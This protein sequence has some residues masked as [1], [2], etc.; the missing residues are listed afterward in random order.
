M[1]LI[2]LR[3]DD[4]DGEILDE[5]SRTV[6]RVAEDVSPAVVRVQVHERR[7]DKEPAGRAGSAPPPREEQAGSGSGFVFTPDG[8]VLTNSHVVHGASRVE[9]ALSGGRRAPAQLV[10]DDPDTDLAVLRVDA[11][12]LIAARFGHS[13]MLRVGQVAIA[14]GNPYGF[15]CTVTSDSAVASLSV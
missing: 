5:Y 9:V 3:Q 15:D 14:I 12:E 11:P 10:G 7:K 2:P 13:S 4:S 1:S 8:F 6:V